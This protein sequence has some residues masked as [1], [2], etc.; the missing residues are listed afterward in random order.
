MSNKPPL[1]GFGQI[2]PTGTVA[3]TCGTGALT[4]LFRNLVV[5]CLLGM[6]GIVIGIVTLKI[7]AE[8]LDKI[9][10]VIGIALSF[11]PIIYA[12]VALITRGRF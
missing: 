9:F 5:A 6:V 8:K 11:I 1:S 12:M 3:V 2:N 4:L 7:G 10:A